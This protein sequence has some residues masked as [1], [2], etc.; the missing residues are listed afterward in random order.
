MLASA[1]VNMKKFASATPAQYDVTLKLKP[2]SVKVVE[3]TLKLNLSCVFLKEG[4]A[5]WVISSEAYPIPPAKSSNCQIV[6]RNLNQSFQIWI[7]I[8]IFLT[9]KEMLLQKQVQQPADRTM[10]KVKMLCCKTSQK[11]LKAVF[12][13]NSDALFKTRPCVSVHCY[14]LS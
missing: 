5:T 9:L 13:D 1:D 7:P 14:F 10:E 8:W 11:N 4:K 12:E 3:A 2:M 6:S